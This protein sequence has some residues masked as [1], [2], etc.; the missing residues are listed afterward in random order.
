MDYS[1]QW[2]YTSVSKDKTV[3][4][5][6]G[7]GW[8]WQERDEQSLPRDGNTLGLLCFLNMR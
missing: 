7:T 2:R 4:N 5:G 3:Q 8:D 1:F 6:A